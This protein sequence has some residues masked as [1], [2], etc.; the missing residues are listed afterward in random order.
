MK[1]TVAP[2]HRKPPQCLL[3]SSLTTIILSAGETGWL[4]RSGHPPGDPQM[5]DDLLSYLPVVRIMILQNLIL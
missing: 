2:I 4:I 5:M 1:I 3:R